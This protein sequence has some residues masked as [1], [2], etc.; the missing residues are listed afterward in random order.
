MKLNIMVN[1]IKLKVYFLIKLIFIIQFIF[2]Y[3]CSFKIL[4]SKTISLEQ[5]SID[6]SIVFVFEDIHGIFRKGDFISYLESINNY[7]TSLR[8]SLIM[9]LNNQNRQDTIIAFGNPPLSGITSKFIISRILKG[10]GCL[11]NC[12]ANEP[13]LKIR[14][15]RYKELYGKS[16]KEIEKFVD[17]VSGKIIF[18]RILGYSH[19]YK[20]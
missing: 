19:F 9:V 1:R 14:Y 3:G 10:D 16:Q 12:I 11:I 5:R 13:I 4:E 8:D 15:I 17:I 20:M 6:S 2:S 18:E 7:D